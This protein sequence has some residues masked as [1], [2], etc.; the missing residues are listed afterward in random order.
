MRKPKRPPEAE[1]VW[2]WDALAQIFSPSV[3]G[4]DP[5]P[6]LHETEPEIAA[7]FR[8]GND[9]YLSGAPL[10]PLLET[11]QEIAFRLL[12]DDYG[13]GKVWRELA[14]ESE[15]T[16]EKYIGKA[17][18]EGSSAL[19]LWEPDIKPRLTNQNAGLKNESISKRLDE[20]LGR[21]D[22]P[23]L[24]EGIL[25]AFDKEGDWGALDILSSLK[26]LREFARTLETDPEARERAFGSSVYETYSSRK[27]NQPQARYIASHLKAILGNRHSTICTTIHAIFEGATDIDPQDI[28]QVPTAKKPSA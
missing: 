15:E 14:K 4:A 11:E 10:P 24:L 1:G 6:L 12:N 21:G 3:L 9:L 23:G 26:E 2:A 13:M 28:K 7:N 5:F 18:F 20:L 25:D 16:A 22:D 17:V 19:L 8:A 27:E